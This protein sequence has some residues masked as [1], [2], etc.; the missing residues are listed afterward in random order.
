MNGSRKKHWEN[1][2]EQKKP[3]EVSWYQ[4]NPAVS[5]EFITSA[6]IDTTAKIIDVGGGASVVVDKLLDMG[7][8]NLTVLDISSK[9]I[10]Y[11]QERL[12]NRTENVNWIEADVTEFEHS[13]QYDFW[14]DRAVFHFLTDAEDSTRYV[15][16]L[17]QAVKKGGYVVIAAFAIDGPVKCSGLDVERYNPEKMKNELGDSFALLNSVSEAHITPWDKE[18]KFIYCYFKKVGN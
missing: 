18:Q 11:A 14:H 13:G 1:V 4:V 8:R 3:S 2:Y 10:Q 9:A 6:K 12:G 15:Q 7:Y 17:K 5:L 16:R